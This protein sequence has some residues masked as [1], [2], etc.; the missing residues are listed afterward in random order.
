MYS[1]PRRVRS[2]DR[3]V[4]SS[5]ART[6]SSMRCSEDSTVSHT[7]AG[8]QRRTTE[9]TSA[10]ASKSRLAGSVPTMNRNRTLG[11]TDAA[12]ESLQ[13]DESAP[14]ERHLLDCTRPWAELP[15][16][17][18]VSRSIL[19]DQCA[20]KRHLNCTY[21]PYPETFSLPATRCSWGGR[22]DRHHDDQAAARIR[23]GAAVLGR[24]RAAPR[25]SRAGSRSRS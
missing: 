12:G 9:S 23:S 15:D 4:C 3:R 8:R 10:R 7:S 16:S 22:S 21:A 1:T 2:A 5:S 24:Q 25:S 18:N 17:G 14:S 13:T 11:A 19:S 6:A 20:E